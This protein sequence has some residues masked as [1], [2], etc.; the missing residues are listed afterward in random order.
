MRQVVDDS[1]AGIEAGRH[2]GMSTIGVLTSHDE[3]TADVVV[4]TLDDLPAGTFNQLTEAC[5]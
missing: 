5:A 1:P 4:S 3:L 2:A